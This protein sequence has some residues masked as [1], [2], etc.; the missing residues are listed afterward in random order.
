M[1]RPTTRLAAALLLCT[2]VT[3]AVAA[4]MTY[5]FDAVADASS[6]FGPTGAAFIGTRAI[7]SFTYDT[8]LIVIG[9]EILAPPDLTIAIR[10]LG[11]DFTA[12]NDND[13]S[14]FPQLGFVGGAPTFLDTILMAGVNG[15]DFGD[16]RL[17]S[18]RLDPDDPFVPGTGGVDLSTRLVIETVPVPSAMALFGL[19]L[20]ALGRVR[21]RSQTT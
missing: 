18:M 20:V 21:R 4:P 14:S 10:V 8:D 5:S 19:G 6:V 3:G 12:V 9:D 15:V 13:Y 1:P 16:P 17:F 7:G 2:F 11:L